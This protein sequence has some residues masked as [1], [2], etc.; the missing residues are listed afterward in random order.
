MKKEKE[1]SVGAVANTPTS[2]QAASAQRTEVI[3][4][5]PQTNGGT[6]GQNVIVDSSA[7]TV[8]NATTVQ[9]A[10]HFIVNPDPLLKQLTTMS[11]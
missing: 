4:E 7:R 5:T 3:N 2:S 8:N 6:G 11:I 1:E 10:S 9:Q